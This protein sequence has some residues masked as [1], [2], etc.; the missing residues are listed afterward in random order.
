MN[1]LLTRVLSLAENLWWSW[2]AESQ[3]LFAS[4]D[5]ALWKATGH[6]PIKTLKLLPPERRE[7]LA[8]DAGFAAQLKRCEQQLAEYLKTPTWFERTQRKHKLQVAYFCAEFAVHECLPQYSG[9]LGVLAGDHVKSASDLGIPF[10]GIGLLYRNGFY[11]H[12]FNADGTTRVTYPQI[13]FAECPIRDTGKIIAVPMGSGVIKAKIWRQIVGRVS[14]Y[15]LDTDIPQ[16]KR[17]EDRDLT[18]H[19]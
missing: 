8:K 6:N 16:N 17:K 11:T 15:L 12:E 3:R 2:N 9:G 14:L 13:D 19:L 10:V 18:R 7:A 5:P 1:D 4:L